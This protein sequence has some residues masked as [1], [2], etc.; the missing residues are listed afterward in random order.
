MEPVTVDGLD[1]AACGT[2]EAV[3]VQ[4]CRAAYITLIVPTQTLEEQRQVL[5]QALETLAAHWTAT[6][7]L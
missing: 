1:W 5:V 6:P 2:L 7:E 3:A 4:G